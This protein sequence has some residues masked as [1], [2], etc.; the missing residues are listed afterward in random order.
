MNAMQTR[1]GRCEGFTLIE[2]LVVV[3]IIGVL[4]A[5]AI[6]AFMGRQGKAYDA[7]IMQDARNAATAQEAYFGDFGSYYSGA[8]VGM[9][10]VNGS[11]G[12]VCNT[13]GGPST[14]GITTS[15]PMASKTCVYSNVGIPNLIC[16]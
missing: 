15:H 5:I 7:R 14:F 3:S 4:A 8:C 1:R 10:G 12:V 9:P 6:P 16:S 11:P 2:L 13:T